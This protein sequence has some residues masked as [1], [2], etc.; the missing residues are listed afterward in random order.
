MYKL[1]NYIFCVLLSILLFF[2]FAASQAVAFTK[3]SILNENTYKDVIE[4]KKIY[5]D[6]YSKLES[7]YQT[8]ENA[9]GI[10]ADVYMNA[11]DEETIKQIMNGCITNAFA[12]INGDADS[13]DYSS[14]YD[15]LEPVKES[16]D[17]FF[18]EYAQSIAYTKDD[19]YYKKTAS[20]Y[21]EAKKEFFETS[22]VYQFSAIDKA[23]YL[24]YAKKVTGYINPGLAAVLAATAILIILLIVANIKNIRNCLYWI[25]ISAGFS[26]VLY[27]ALCIYLKATNYFDKFAIKSPRIFS[28]MT[29]AFNKFADELIIIN[30]AVLA[31]SVIFMVIYILKG[32]EKIKA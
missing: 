23:G 11:A 8:K 6:V 15:K 16:I 30:V 2:A 14:D 18:D 24:K 7:D 19:A 20:V 4:S 17:S 28:A 25:S 5:S 9:T 26:S 22:D 31:V 1:R 13:L 10:P 3:Y 21:E 12:Y 29:G 27:L 32:K